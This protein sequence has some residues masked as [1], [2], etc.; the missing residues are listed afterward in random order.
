MSEQHLSSETALSTIAARGVDTE[1]SQQYRR[2]AQHHRRDQFTA[3]ILF[4]EPKL[5]GVSQD[6]SLYPDSL[7]T[8]ISNFLCTP[9]SYKSLYGR[10]PSRHSTNWPRM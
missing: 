7:N 5:Y 4:E 6:S 10:V 3:I 2:D 9:L 8:R 1:V